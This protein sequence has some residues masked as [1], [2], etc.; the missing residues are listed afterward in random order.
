MEDRINE[1]PGVEAA[2]ITFA[3]KQ[4][5][6]AADNPDA[7]LPKFQEICT[8]IEPD[9]KIVPRGSAAGGRTTVFLLENPGA[10][11]CAPTM[12]D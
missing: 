10:A 7:L 12:E 11:P 9:V 4:L 3:T 8:S 2:T 6:V 5:R 1:L